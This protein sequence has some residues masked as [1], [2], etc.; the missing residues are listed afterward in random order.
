MYKLILKDGTEIDNL[1]KTGGGNWF[2]GNPIDADVLTD[3]NLKEV[4]VIENGN[5]MMMYDMTSDFCD[6]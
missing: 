2:S 3:E 6:E 4:K 1:T 5:E